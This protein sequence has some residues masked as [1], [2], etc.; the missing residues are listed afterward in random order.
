ML[1]G[2]YVVSGEDD[3]TVRVWNLQEK[4]QNFL[5]QGHTDT[6]T[7]IVITYDN[8]YAISCGKDKTVRVWNLQE[9]RQDAVLCKNNSKSIWAKKYPEVISFIKS[10]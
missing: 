8:K 7:S 3:N 4:H 6:V 1:H 9:K 2:M 5:L 10:L